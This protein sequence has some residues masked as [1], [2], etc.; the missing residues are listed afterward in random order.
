MTVALGEINA[1]QRADERCKSSEQQSEIR[2][3]KIQLRKILQNQSKCMY[4]RQ[5]AAMSSLHS[6]L[7]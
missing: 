6:K 3:A 7:K 5:F 2:C 1:V 4:E